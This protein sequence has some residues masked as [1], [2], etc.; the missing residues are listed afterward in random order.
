MGI[1]DNFENAWDPEFQ[2]ESNPMPVID[3]MG[4]P[5]E[6]PSLAVKVFAEACCTTCSCKTT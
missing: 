1:L 3:N 4:R 6:D 2:Y 5:T